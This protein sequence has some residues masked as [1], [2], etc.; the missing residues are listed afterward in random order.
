LVPLQ[1]MPEL[2]NSWHHFINKILQFPHQ[3]SWKTETNETKMEQ[4]FNYRISFVGSII[5]P[6]IEE[7]FKYLLL[8]CTFPIS[9]IWRFSKQYKSGKSSYSD[10]SAQSLFIMFIALCGGCGIAIMENIGYLAACQWEST[11]PY[12]LPNKN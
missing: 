8:S 7:S 4:P 1:L 2:S 6:I 5:A 10:Y 3:H 12:C 11:R 9:F